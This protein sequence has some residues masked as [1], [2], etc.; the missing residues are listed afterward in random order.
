[1]PELAGRCRVSAARQNSGRRPRAL[2]GCE[3]APPAPCSPVRPWRLIVL[4]CH[5]TA[6]RA[7]APALR[8]PSAAWASQLSRGTRTP[9]APARRTGI[10]PPSSSRAPRPVPDASL[11]RSRVPPRSQRRTQFR[12]QAAPWRRGTPRHGSGPGS[13]AL[14]ASYSAS[15]TTPRTRQRAQRSTTRADLRSRRLQLCL[16]PRPSARVH[17]MRRPGSLRASARPGHPRAPGVQ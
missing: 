13:Q 10:R 5:P 1:M 11:Q 6:D 15:A 9:R 3:Q 4:S 8:P 12:A 7:P 2:K 14:W 16:R 17:S